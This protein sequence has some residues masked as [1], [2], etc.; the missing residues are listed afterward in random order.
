MLGLGASFFG[1]GAN[2]RGLGANFRGLGANFL[3]LGASFRGLL[4]ALLVDPM[5]RSSFATLAFLVVFKVLIKL[6]FS[7]DIVG[8]PLS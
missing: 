2:F 6:F 1:L 5:V 3:G 7:M 4:V 8:F